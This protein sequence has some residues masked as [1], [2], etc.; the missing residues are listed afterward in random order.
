MIYPELNKK[1][2]TTLYINK[3]FSI[4]KISTILGI[5]PNIV[6]RKIREFKIK[7]SPEKIKECISST[8]IER[9]GSP[10]FVNSEEGKNKIRKTNLER[11]GVENPFQ[12]KIIQDK[13]KQTCLEKYGV[14]SIAQDREFRQRT[15]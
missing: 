2:L 1:N 6:G 7:K 12:S 4:E 3:N 9:Y 14:E 10:A 8:N 5:R 13:V 15:Q 11:Y